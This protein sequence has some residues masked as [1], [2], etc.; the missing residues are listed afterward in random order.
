[1]GKLALVKLLYLPQDPRV[2][3]AKAASMVCCAAALLLPMMLEFELVATMAF[4]NVM[5][6][7]LIFSWLVIDR[8]IA[9]SIPSN[10]T[11][12]M[13]RLYLDWQHLVALR[14]RC[15]PSFQ[16]SFQSMSAMVSETPQ[17]THEASGGSDLFCIDGIYVREGRHNG[18]P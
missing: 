6:A 16:D 7:L 11:W 3:F 14:V 18:K 8:T 15:A 5:M 10:W 13:P 1:M 17:G 12:K 4:P 2:H 9:G